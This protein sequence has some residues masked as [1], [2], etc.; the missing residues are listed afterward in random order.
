MMRGIAPG[1]RSIQRIWL[2]QETCK[3]ERVCCIYGFISFI[4]KIKIKNFSC[5]FHAFILGKYLFFEE[6]FMTK[7]FFL[8]QSLCVYARGQPTRWQRI[9][10]KNAWKNYIKKVPNKLPK[11]ITIPNHLS[12]RSNQRNLFLFPVNLY[13]SLSIHEK[14]QA[15]CK[16]I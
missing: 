16:R 5:Y 2:D 8:F 7:I 4:F 6:N 10:S 11:N 14:L 15:T 13:N 3:H 9:Q 1:D 12:L